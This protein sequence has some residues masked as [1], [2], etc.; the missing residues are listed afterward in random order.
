MPRSTHREAHRVNALARVLD[1][2]HLPVGLRLAQEG[3][4][5]FLDGGV[6]TAKDRDLNQYFFPG[7]EK[8]SRRYSPGENT[9]KENQEQRNDRTQSGDRKG[10]IKIRM[11]P[12][13]QD[14]E[15]AIQ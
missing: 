11:Q 7:G 4:N 6:D 9:Q 15:H 13:G 5:Q 14:I 8:S 3:L 10:Q 12:R 1:H 2:D